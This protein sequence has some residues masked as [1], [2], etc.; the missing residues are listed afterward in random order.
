MTYDPS[1]PPAR[2]GERS[3]PVLSTA[4]F[5]CAALALLFVPILF[6]PAGIMLGLRAHSANEPLGAW[7]AIA[8]GVAMIVGLIAGYL[9]RPS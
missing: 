5:G 9:V 1:R 8:S 7:A 2:P 3:V 4:G 6:G